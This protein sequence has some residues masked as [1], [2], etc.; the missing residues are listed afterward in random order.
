MCASFADRFTAQGGRP[1]YEF[2]ERTEPKIVCNKFAYLAGA[3]SSAFS[4]GLSL[5]SVGVEGPRIVI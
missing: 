4:A 1:G 2:G 3:L 5:A